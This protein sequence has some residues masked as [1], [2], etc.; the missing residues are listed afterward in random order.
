M[1]VIDLASDHAGVE[2]KTELGAVVAEY[3]FEPLDLGVHDAEGRLPG[4]R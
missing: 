3:G 2:L 4:H 1:A